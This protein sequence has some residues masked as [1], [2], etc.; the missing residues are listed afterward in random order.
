MKL[1]ELVEKITS[2]NYYNSGGKSGEKETEEAPLVLTPD[3]LMEYS[4]PQVVQD[5]LRVNV[6]RL[7]ADSKNRYETIVSI[8]PFLEISAALRREVDHEQY[9]QQVTARPKLV[10]NKPFDGYRQLKIQ[11]AESGVFG[12]DKVERINAFN[13]DD[14]KAY[15]AFRLDAEFPKTYTQSSFGLGLNEE[16]LKTRSVIIS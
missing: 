5:Y 4:L 9:D 3:L 1:P 6:T 7:H 13:E 11:L 16:Q 2:E 14:T 12:H 8:L 15:R 10:V